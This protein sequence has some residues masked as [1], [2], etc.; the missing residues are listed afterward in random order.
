MT[1]LLIVEDDPTDLDLILEMVREKFE[2]LWAPT[3]KDAIQHLKNGAVDA[4]LLDVNLPDSRDSHHAVSEVK[5]HRGHAAIV[6]LS[7]E[8]DEAKI[9]QG[10]AD[11]ADGWL[12]KGSSRAKSVVFELERAIASHRIC[13]KVREGIQHLKN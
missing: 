7:G 10:L 5:I 6:V 4:V 13:C 9:R 12:V 1:R 2:T 8:S 11:N 3:L